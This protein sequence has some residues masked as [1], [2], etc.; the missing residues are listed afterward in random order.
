MIFL[1][2]RYT[3][4][5]YLISKYYLMV[6]LLMST[7]LK[8]NSLSS[9]SYQFGLRILKYSWKNFKNGT[10]S[11]CEINVNNA[12]IFCIM[13]IFSCVF[14]LLWMARYR[15]FRNIL[16]FPALHT[17]FNILDSMHT[18]AP[19]N[20]LILYSFSEEGEFAFF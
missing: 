9:V 7:I 18:T 3:C 4:G 10:F 2:I 8:E 17:H 16:S 11:Q 15:D 14:W 6:C 20:M 1:Y 12:V 5:I 19:E 13:M